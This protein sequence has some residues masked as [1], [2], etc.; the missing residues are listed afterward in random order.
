MQAIFIGSRGGH[1][2]AACLIWNHGK[3]QPIQ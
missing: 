2:P 1:L 3:K